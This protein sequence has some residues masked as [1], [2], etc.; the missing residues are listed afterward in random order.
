M[1]ANGAQLASDRLAP[2]VTDTI[3]APVR[4]KVNRFLADSYV[5]EIK[6]AGG[7]DAHNNVHNAT[8][9]GLVAATITA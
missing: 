5:V 8:C 3:F 7:S 6:G 2:D 1:G 9:G 4:G